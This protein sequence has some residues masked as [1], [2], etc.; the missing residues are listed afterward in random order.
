MTIQELIIESHQTAVEHG[1]WETERN[2]PEQLML[3]VSEL[4]EV[5]EE[6]RIYGLSK[7]LQN[8]NGKPSGI[9]VE[10][11]DLFIRVA[12]TCGRYNIPLE[13]AL[14]LKLAYNKT[15]PYRH[16]GKLA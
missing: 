16:G 11:A 12:D 14:R 15:R 1:W 8:E 10:F 13:E 6:Y 5:L 7:I 3:M 2:F 9:A 4:S